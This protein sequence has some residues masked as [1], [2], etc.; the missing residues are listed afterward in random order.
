LVGRVGNNYLWLKYN[1]KQI[2]PDDAGHDPVYASVY[3]TSRRPFRDQEPDV[4]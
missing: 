1:K 3:L 4:E 2:G